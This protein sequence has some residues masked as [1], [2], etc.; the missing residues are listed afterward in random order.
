[1]YILN[2]R[3]L[4]EVDN[5]PDIKDIIFIDEKDD[6]SCLSKDDKIIYIDTNFDQF[7]K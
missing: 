3:T 7:P 6:M 5:I 4:Q 1:M 2:R